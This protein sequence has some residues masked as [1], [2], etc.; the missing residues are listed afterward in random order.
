MPTIINGTTGVDKIQDGVVVQADLASGV[1]GTGPAFGAEMTSDQ[2]ISTNVWTKLTYSTEIFDTDNCFD[3]TTNYRFTP[4]VAGYY[5]ILAVNSIAANAAANTDV[6]LAIYKN[7]AL[8]K[9]AAD[10]STDTGRYGSLCIS[11][12][13]YA[14]GSSDYFEVYARTPSTGGYVNGTTFSSFSACFVRAA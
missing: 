7:G 5:S 1:A 9:Q 14:N 8:V 4:N 11:Y 10:R 12:V 6:N 3:P 13:A 2:T